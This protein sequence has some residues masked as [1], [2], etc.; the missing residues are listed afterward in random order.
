MVF[1]AGV[2]LCRA[3]VSSGLWVDRRELAVL[4]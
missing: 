1:A 3:C 2:A 4:S